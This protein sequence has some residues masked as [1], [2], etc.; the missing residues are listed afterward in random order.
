M[1]FN[2]DLE[3]EDSNPSLALIYI[4]IFLSLYVGGGGLRVRRRFASLGDRCDHRLD[5]YLVINSHKN[6]QGGLQPPSKGLYI[7]NFLRS[8]SLRLRRCTL[9]PHEVEMEE[10]TSKNWR[11][12]SHFWSLI[13][14]NLYIP[15]HKSASS[16]T[17]LHRKIQQPLQIT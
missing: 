4:L 13:V 3:V 15:H 17:Q 9:L 14:D 16:P 5:W 7:K 8:W 10:N 12:P 1:S 6:S 2:S 11:M